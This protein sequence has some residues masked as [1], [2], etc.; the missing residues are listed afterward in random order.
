MKYA[1]IREEALK[2]KVAQDFFGKFDVCQ[3]S[4]ESKNTPCI[5]KWK[6]CKIIGKEIVNELS[7]DFY[8]G[9]IN[10]TTKNLP[11]RGVKFFA[12]SLKYEGLS[13]D[14]T[15]Q[16]RKEYDKPFVYMDGIETQGESRGKGLGIKVLNSFYSIVKKGVFNHLNVKDISG[17]FWKKM[18]D[19]Y[20]FI[21]DKYTTGYEAG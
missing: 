21:R 16:D 8:G 4:L 15:V 6:K 2:N 11:K 9:T 20:D 14:V 13:M 18:L 7:I 17:G 3:S 5:E 12:I 19:R 10:F 1:N